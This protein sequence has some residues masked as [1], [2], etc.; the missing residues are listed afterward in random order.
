MLTLV[1]VM[2]LDMLIIVM[3]MMVLKISVEKTKKTVV[4]SIN[5]L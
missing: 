4:F 1:K 2:N 5:S 3:F